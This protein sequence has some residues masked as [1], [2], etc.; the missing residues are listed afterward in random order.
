MIK[1]VCASAPFFPRANATVDLD[2]MPL[3]PRWLILTAVVNSG[4][5]DNILNMLRNKVIM[6]FTRRLQSHIPL[7]LAQRASMIP[8]CQSGVPSGTLTF[9]LEFLRIIRI[10]QGGQRRGPRLFTGRLISPGGVWPGLRFGRDIVSRLGYHLP[11]VN[12]S[13]HMLQPQKPIP[14]CVQT[15]TRVRR[16]SIASR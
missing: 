16:A 6:H 9:N 14:K 8:F 7:C 13:D 10:R 4:G 1:E 15:S 5:P 11:I 2:V 12:S 3:F